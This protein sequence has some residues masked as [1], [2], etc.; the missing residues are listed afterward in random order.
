MASVQPT[1]IHSSATSALAIQESSPTVV[2]I[3][4]WDVRLGA[5][6]SESELTVPAAALP[7][8]TTPLSANLSLQL[9]SP[10][11]AALAILPSSG[12][13]GRSLIYVIPLTLPSASVL[14][15]VVGKQALTK[16]YLAGEHTIAARAQRT[17]PIPHPKASKE[18]LALLA[19][20]QE[21]RSRLLDSFEHLS[22]PLEKGAGEEVDAAI[23]QAE[24]LFESFL[25]EERARLSEYLAYKAAVE[26][27]KEK[28]RRVAA[29]FEKE[30]LK[31]SGKKYRQ[32]RSKIEEA[33]STAGSDVPWYEVT[34]K[35]IRLVGDSYRY[36][37]YDERK[38]AE[39]L[40]H[41]GRMMETA[42]RTDSS[43]KSPSRPPVKEV[44]C[45]L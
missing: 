4:I 16:K 17:E 8:S 23:V 22:K 30:S 29:L 35:R 24:Q 44:S 38:A 21:A 27:V 3:L 2:T 28:E 31:T 39:K 1:T 45:F 20:S 18:K 41:E 25:N 37:Y 9:N 6:I 7:S 32:M 11:T 34:A 43:E 12:S 36:Q 10:D 13:T 26:E 5:V 15:A 40:Q 33:I 19:S 14:A 42:M